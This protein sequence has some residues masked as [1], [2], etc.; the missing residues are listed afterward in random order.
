MSGKALSRLAGLPMLPQLNESVNSS[1][2]KGNPDGR[3]DRRMSQAN[4]QGPGET[5][6]AAYNTRAAPERHRGVIHR[7]RVPGG[8]NRELFWQWQQTRR[9]DRV[10]PPTGPG[11]HWKSAR[12]RT[13]VR[14]S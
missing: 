13:T 11:W 1:R 14:W 2:G 5:D 7:H 3:P 6:P 4:A 9:Q 10:W 12:A 8:D